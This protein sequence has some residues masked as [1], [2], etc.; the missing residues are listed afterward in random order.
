MRKNLLLSSLFTLVIGFQSLFAQDICNP[1]GNVLVYSNY[2]GGSFTINIDENV[3]NI[4]IGLCS[5]ESMNVTITGPYVANVVEVLYAGYNSDG[6]T[7][8]SGVDAGIVNIL[9]YPPVTLFDADGYGFMICAYE[10]DTDYVPG[11]CNTV[12]QAVDYF[13]TNLAGDFRYSFYQYGVFT[14]TQNMSDGGNCCIGAEACAIVVD[15]GQ[16]ASICVGDS[17]QLD[18][19]GALNYVWFPVTDLTDADVSNPYASPTETITYILTGT[20]AD[21]CAGLD[22][23]TITVNPYPTATI[24]DMGDGNLMATG[25]GTYQWYFNGEPIAAA[26]NETYVAT[27]TGYYS[28]EVTSAAGCSV[29]TEEIIVVVQSINNLY[30]NAV[31]CYPNPATDGFV[32]SADHSIVVESIQLISLTGQ[33]IEVPQSVGNNVITVNTQDV[34]KG[35]YTVKIQTNKGLVVKQIHVL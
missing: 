18:G 24:M 12:D 29:L 11:G 6:S 16:D 31:H 10:C 2:D 14:G 8:V 26:V 9:N 28:V 34:S 23:V 21:G 35:I 7:S 27:A 17:V 33:Y 5:Y 3:P 15:A 32:V 30:S 1:A 19:S 22:T 20:D 25:G 4:R 13:A